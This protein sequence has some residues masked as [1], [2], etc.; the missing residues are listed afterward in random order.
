MAKQSS[1]ILINW[2]VTK[3]AW[4]ENYPLWMTYL[5]WQLYILV[6][7]GYPIISTIRYEN[8]SSNQLGN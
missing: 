2:C 6:L 1:S 7:I 8:W 4:K 5:T 3:V